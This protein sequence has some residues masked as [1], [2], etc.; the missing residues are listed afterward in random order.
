MKLKFVL[1]WYQRGYCFENIDK[2]NGTLRYANY[3]KLYDFL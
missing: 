2:I 1:V 3:N